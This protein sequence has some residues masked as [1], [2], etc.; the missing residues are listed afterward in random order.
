MQ[1]AWNTQ[2]N[3]WN[4][5]AQWQQPTKPEGGKWDKWGVWKPT[6][7]PPQSPRQAAAYA[8][9]PNYSLFCKAGLECPHREPPDGDGTCMNNGVPKIHVADT[10]SAYHINHWKE[11]SAGAKAK[12]KK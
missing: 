6:K 4:Q 8:M 1:A 12:A 7:T 10:V 11:Q 2:N 3:I 9:N 5:D